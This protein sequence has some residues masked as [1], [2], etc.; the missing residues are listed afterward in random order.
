MNLVEEVRPGANRYVSGSG[1]L[2]D[3]EHYLA[4]FDRVAIITGVNSYQAFTHYYRK[5]LTL[6]V[7][8]YDGT[9]SIENSQTLADKIGPAD[10]ILSIGGGRVVDT[11]KL[12][13]ENL[14]CEL[15][16]VPTLISN[17]APYT[18]V[19]AIYHPD[20]TFNKVGYFK[21]SSYLTLVDWQFLLATPVDYFI[22]G[23]GD[24]LTKWYE[25]EGIVRSIPKE[26]LSAS[27]RLGFASAQEIFN[28][29]FADSAS[30]LEALKNQKVTPAFG[31][32]AD[33]VIELSGTVGGFAGPYGRMAGA[34]ALH[35]GFSLLTETHP[36]LHGAKVAYGVLVQ[37]A[38]TDDFD[39]VKRLLPF[40][41]KSQL[42]T[43]L[44]ELNLPCFNP[45]QLRATAIFAS[46]P[47]ESYVLIDQAVNADKILTAIERLE[48]FVA[49]ANNE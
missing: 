27:A 46:S 36:I 18:P 11:A 1:V 10:A 14:S 12:V 13:A 5:N 39:E 8:Y 35:N 2:N 22:A 6:P 33:T 48:N 28:I 15:V 9:A 29:L 31:R 26:K 21:K 34:H 38:Y 20:H 7:F 40:Y 32:I 3:L 30:A 42:P 47:E 24:T 25:I 16:I 19:A 49:F 17:C 43:R 41:R 23:I 44:N 37:L 45:E 4:V